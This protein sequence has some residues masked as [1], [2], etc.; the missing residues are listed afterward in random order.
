LA[1]ADEALAGYVVRGTEEWNRAVNG[2]PLPKVR[3]YSKRFQWAV[4]AGLP[5]FALYRLVK[6]YERPA[7][8]S[9]KVDSRSWAI[10]YAEP[11][12]N[13]PSLA[14]RTGPI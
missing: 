5:G 13:Y 9:D 2:R 12:A 10:Y 11:G 7:F 3:E 6:W 14:K 1:D 4:V 8:R